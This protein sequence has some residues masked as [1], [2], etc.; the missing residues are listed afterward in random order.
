MKIGMKRILKK[1]LCMILGKKMWD[2][3]R[4]IGH[5]NRAIKI[6]SKR[7]FAH[8]GKETIQRI[9]KLYAN[10]CKFKKEI[11]F[12]NSYGYTTF[13]YEFSKE[14]TKLIKEAKCGYDEDDDFYVMYNEKKIYVSIL[15][16]VLLIIE[17]NNNSPHRYFSDDFT[18]NDGDVFVDIGA[19]EGLIS[20]DVIDKASKIFL[21]EAEDR[22]KKKL[23]KTFLP[24]KDKVTII[25]AFAGD[26]DDSENVTVDSVLKNIDKPIV[27][28]MDVEGN[29]K[30]VL[31]GMQ[32]TLSRD[33]VKI[34][35][36]TYHRFGDDIRF[37]EIFAE[38]GYVCS[39][40]DGFMVRYEEPFF[41][42]GLLR[43]R[44]G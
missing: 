18:L 16:Y 41:I 36:C 11:D 35:I 40:T 2:S 39:L 1:I 31:K 29:E 37:K 43:A 30:T 23:E 4:I 7:R 5:K 14:Y 19:A 33:N 17:Q 15:E 24:Y 21:I 25:S 13:P 3:I 12:L 10:S 44:K 38:K 22:W 32:G 34:A 27:I 42:K 20:L 6:L 8:R 26:H 28:K 9:N